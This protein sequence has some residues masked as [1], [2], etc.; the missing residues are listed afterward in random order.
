MTIGLVAKARGT[1]EVNANP[2]GVPQIFDGIG[3]SRWTFDKTFTGG[4]QGTSVVAMTAAGIEG[5]ET[6]V[7]VAVERVNGTLDGRSGAFVMTHHAERTKDSN[8][9][10]ITVAPGVSTGE[11]SG[12]RGTMEIGPDHSYELEYEL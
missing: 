1:F 8:R 10:I 5:T 3:H 9:L 2:D 11:L 12:L 6:A 4:L 7:Y